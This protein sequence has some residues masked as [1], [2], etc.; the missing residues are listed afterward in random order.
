M[1]P[2]ILLKYSEDNVWHYLHD[3][4]NDDDNRRFYS[5]IPVYVVTFLIT[6]G[7]HKD[8]LCTDGLVS[9]QLQTLST[10]DQ[11]KKTLHYQ[12]IVL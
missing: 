7:S 10:G 8:H 6:N 12:M 1:C 2:I 9:C 3:C 4:A 5:I 11:Q